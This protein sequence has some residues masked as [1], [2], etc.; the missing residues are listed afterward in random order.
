MDE[1]NMTSDS[2]SKQ[3]IT[4]GAAVVE[5]TMLTHTA[6]TGEYIDDAWSLAMFWHIRNMVRHR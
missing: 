4:P 2:Q 3:L 1:I 6:D 5:T